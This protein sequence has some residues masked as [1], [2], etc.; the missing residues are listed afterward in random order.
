MSFLGLYPGVA[1]RL[2]GVVG[3]T[4]AFQSVFAAYSVPNKTDKF[5]DLAGSLGFISTTLLSL[6]YP[7]LR[8]LVSGPRIPFKPFD[9]ASHHPRQLIVSALYL[10][11][12]GR[13]GTFLFQRVLKHGKDSRFDDLKT[14]PKKF[15]AMWFGQALWITLVSLPAVL[16]NVLPPAAQPALGLKDLI[17]VGIWAAGFG[18]EIIADREKSAWRAAK[19]DKK[20]SEKFIS[21][22]AWSLSRHP[23]YLG[24]VVLQ[25][26]PPLLAFAA[27]PYPARTL[28]LLSPLFTYALLRYASGVPPLEASAEKKWGSDP[29]WRK[30]TE[31]TSVLFPWPGGAG[32]GKL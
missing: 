27:V 22:G 2:A 21:S 13:L 6:Y 7:A 14:D 8:S 3:F 15:S 10:L 29:E 20:H 28:T 18:F 24:E 31:K 5:Y 1:S 26:G 23:N 32:K 25:A 9:F 11:W 16:I 30:Y 17:G 4:F 12:A 19:D